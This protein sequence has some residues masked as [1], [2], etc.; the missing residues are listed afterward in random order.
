[1]DPRRAAEQDVDPNIGP[2]VRWKWTGDDRPTWDLAAV[3]RYEGLM[4][5]VGVAVYGARSFAPRVLRI[6]GTRM[7]GTN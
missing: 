6:G 3:A 5:P 7:G 1:M 2:I 4:V